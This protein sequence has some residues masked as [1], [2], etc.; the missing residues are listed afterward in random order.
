VGW[1]TNEG[2]PED[3]SWNDAAPPTGTAVAGPK[4]V[5]GGRDVGD[6]VV[7]GDDGLVELACRSEAAVVVEPDRVLGVGPK[8]TA[9]EAGASEDDAN[10]PI[11]VTS[12]P[13]RRPTAAAAAVHAPLSV[14]VRRSISSSFRWRGSVGRLVKYGHG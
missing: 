9:A 3:G 4:R 10:R 5:P 6:D 2:S 1:I 14:T 13:P 12:P 8:P 11:P 7:G